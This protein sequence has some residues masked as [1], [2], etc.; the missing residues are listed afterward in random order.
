LWEALQHYHHYRTTQ[1]RFSPKT[2]MHEKSGLLAF[3][4]KMGAD[5]TLDSLTVEDLDDW[6]AWLEVAE[7][8][9]KTRLSQLRSFLTYCREMRGWL[10]HDPTLMLRVGKTMPAQWRR[11][12]A[13][14][15]LSL[16]DVTADPWERIILALAMN[17]AC[18][19]SELAELRVRDVNLAA[20]EISVRVDKTEQADVMPVTVEL[21]AEL[22]RWLAA[23]RLVCPDLTRDS[24][25]IPSRFFQPS[26]NRVYYRHLQPYKTP[27]RVVQAALGRL[28]WESSLR[29]G[30]HTVRRSVARLFFDMVSAE[31]GE[32]EAILQTMALLHHVE[33]R[34]TLR[35]IGYDRQ[36]EARNAT[37]KGKRFLTRGMAV[38]PV[39]IAQ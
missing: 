28:G 39:R 24:Y 32:S 31:G 23:Y 29:E 2:W 30:V 35:Y 21:A 38:R 6:W 7:S 16:L 33:P 18:R 5:R 10:D 1:G 3:A 25:L 22:Q 14:E 26:N 13:E 4:D 12:T 9:R 36:V 17:L 37:L 15:L 19:G 11:L 34:T 27:H 20:D 8:T